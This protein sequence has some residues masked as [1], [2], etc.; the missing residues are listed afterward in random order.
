LGGT[1]T[2]NI[3][4]TSGAGSASATTAISYLFFADAANLD[5]RR[6]IALSD[7]YDPLFRS[8]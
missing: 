8:H 6:S 5:E 3:L 1:H 7:D 4:A 2:P